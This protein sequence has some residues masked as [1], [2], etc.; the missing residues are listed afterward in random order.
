MENELSKLVRL[1]DRRPRFSAHR[2]EMPHRSKE[3]FT[4]TQKVA[5]NNIAGK[6]PAA[7]IPLPGPI[8]EIIKI[9]PTQKTFTPTPKNNK[10]F[11]TCLLLGLGA[12]TIAGVAFAIYH[13][14]KFE[15]NDRPTS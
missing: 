7:E 14:T 13:T 2:F 5:G 9:E 6:I 12:F 4:Q 8:P 10:R 11:I 3:I 1:P 15:E